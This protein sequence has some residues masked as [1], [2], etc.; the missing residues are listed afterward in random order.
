MGW[1]SSLLGTGG[2]GA[3]GAGAGAGAAAG[4]GAT[5]AGVGAAAVPTALQTAA[6]GGALQAATTEAIAGATVPVAA[7]AVAAGSRGGALDMLPQ[8]Q[9]MIAGRTSP[10]LAEGFGNTA[11]PGSRAAALKSGVGIRNEDGSVNWG[12]VFNKTEDYFRVVGKEVTSPLL[13][14][15]L[16]GG[17][18]GSLPSRVSYPP[19]GAGGGGRPGENLGL[20][21]LASVLQGRLAGMGRR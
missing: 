3:A 4:A 6:A 21:L 15:A 1:L 16:S 5:A 19:G 9:Q 14:S 12:E 2:A 8:F 10:A 13:K 18:G 20:S 11:V 7:Q 17:G